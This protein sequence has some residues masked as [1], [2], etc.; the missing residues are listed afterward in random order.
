MD[1]YDHCF[2]G[3]STFDL[4]TMGYS[5]PFGPIVPERLIRVYLH[6]HLGP[7]AKRAAKQ[8]LLTVGQFVN[9]ALRQYLAERKRNPKK[10]QL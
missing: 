8:E 7:L 9:L 4:T 5:S 10:D 3:V 1:F 6:R 2:L